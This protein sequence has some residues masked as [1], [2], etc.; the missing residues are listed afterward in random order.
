MFNTKPTNYTK[1]L[2]ECCGKV[3][4]CPDEYCHRVVQ[5]LCGTKYSPPIVEKTKKTWD[6]DSQ[7]WV[8]ETDMAISQEL[9]YKAIFERK[10]AST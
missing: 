9:I 8:L 1:V 5:Y 3:Y 7:E 6:S 4:I 10:N 2:W